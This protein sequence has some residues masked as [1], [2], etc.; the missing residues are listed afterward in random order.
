M[1][2]T[3]ELCRSCGGRD[4]LTNINLNIEKGTFAAIIGANGAGKSTLAKHFNAAL[5][6]QRGSVEVDGFNTRDEMHTFDIRER[7]GMVFQNPD[8]QAVAAVVEDDTA[9]APENLGLSEAEI[10]R[11]IEFALSSAGIAHLRRRS[12]S[13]LSGG[14]KQLV[15]I[16]GILAMRPGYII[17]DEGT[18][19]LDPPSRK[20]ILDCVKQLRHELGIA[21]IWITHYMD[22]AAQ[23]DRV[24]VLDNGHIAADGTPSEVF[25]N[26]SVIESCGLELPKCAELLFMLR[27]SG[28]D[29]E[30]LPLTPH[31]CA[32]EIQRL[33][34]GHKN[35]R[36]K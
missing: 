2:Q 36:D 22:E 10:T 26:V 9:F 11:R 25:E 3:T 35:D 17:F 7:V 29:T 24:I 21:I 19:M 13:T 5:V 30:K 32:M 31:E 20:R 12:I 14:E 33:L 18:A 34:K 8:S 15:S 23:A 4:I 6:P 16:A 27:R 1:I 28:Y